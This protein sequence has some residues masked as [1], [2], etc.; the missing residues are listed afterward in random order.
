LESLISS[1]YELQ[2]Y[3]QEYMSSHH[4]SKSLLL[5]SGIYTENIKN[6]A[7]RFYNVEEDY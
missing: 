2:E 6:Y 5:A 4:V 3:I 7:A 1:Y